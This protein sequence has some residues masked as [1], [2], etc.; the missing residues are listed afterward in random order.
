MSV[1]QDW[2]SHMTLN[3]SVLKNIAKEMGMMMLNFTKRQ[4]VD[5]SK[6]VQFLIIF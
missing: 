3:I 5:P 4:P 2:F 6:N 1:F